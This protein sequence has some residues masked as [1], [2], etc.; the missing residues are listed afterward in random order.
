MVQIRLFQ[1]FTLLPAVHFYSLRDLLPS[2]TIYKFS[3]GCFQGI[4]AYIASRPKTSDRN[5]EE[6][7]QRRREYYQRQQNQG[8]LILYH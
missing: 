3:K 1:Y 5:D 7:E 6:E 2:C 8:I 4:N